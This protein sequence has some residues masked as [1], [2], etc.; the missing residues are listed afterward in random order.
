MYGS[1]GFGNKIIYKAILN[2]TGL[3]DQ[4]CE[5]NEAPW[6]TGSERELPQT[7]I[8]H[9]FLIIINCPS[10]EESSKGGQIQWLFINTSEN[11]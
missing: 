11:C 7:A 10:L 5:F 4:L 9:I 2:T 6:E 3:M 1:W 8:N